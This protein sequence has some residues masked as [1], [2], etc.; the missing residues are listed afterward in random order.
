MCSCQTVGKVV[1]I[2]R[3]GAVRNYGTNTI[4]EKPNR[5]GGG[6]GGGKNEIFWGIG[7]IAS[8]FSRGLI[9]KYVKCSRCDQ[10]KNYMEFPGVLVLG[11][12]NF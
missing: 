3:M 11:L 12:K 8:E 2:T 1:C 5:G 4:M 6:G 7:E 9:K 10:V